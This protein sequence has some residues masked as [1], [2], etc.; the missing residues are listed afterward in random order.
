VEA[1]KKAFCQEFHEREGR[2]VSVWQDSSD[3]RPGTKWTAELEDVVKNAA[4]LLAIVSPAYQ[5][6]PW[7]GEEYRFL[8]NHYGTLEALKV[9]TIYRFFKI[10]KL[11]TEH[12]ILPELQDVRFFS[13][14]KEPYSIESP[15]FKVAI[16][17]AVTAIRELFR[18]MSNGK[19]SVYLATGPIEMVTDRTRLEDELTGHGYKVR[20]SF[21]LDRRF[22][23]ETLVSEVDPCSRA[24]FLLGAQHDP[25]V[26]QQID[27]AVALNKP[28]LFWIHP[29]LSL[30]AIPEQQR[31]LQH[32]QDRRD[33]PAGSEIL[34]GQSIPALW[35]A[36][37][38]KLKPAEPKPAP[39][40]ESTK[41]SVYLIF[42]ATLSAESEAAAHL[43]GILENRNLQVIQ[44]NHFDDHQ[45][46]MNTSDAAL[47]LRTTNPKSDDWWLRLLAQEVILNTR[48]ASK[49]LVL[50]DT[51]RLKL[52]A[53]DIP[54]LPYSQPFSP[55]ALDPFIDKLQRA[56]GA[57]AG[58]R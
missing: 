24:I 17:K 31:L 50:A 32:L 38:P 27:Q 45:D 42:D 52:T 56:R 44:S 22:P 33:L 49:A 55:Q 30:N 10:F 5:A 54:V 51:T 46:L 29:R 2:P 26:S 9:E 43:S 11:P 35:N 8:L 21:A 47:L 39:T 28:C 37:E 25:F 58:S 16:T 18:L 13:Q 4:A 19:T 36:L 12:D 40:T 7:C 57:H 15:E 53:S 34:G 14:T 48:F 41:P 1:F 3:L 20:P 23:A 6:S